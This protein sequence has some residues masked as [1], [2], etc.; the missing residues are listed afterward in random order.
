MIGPKLGKIGNFDFH[1]AAEAID[2]GH[3]AARKMTA[4]IAA[5][6]TVA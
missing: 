3:E 1:H 6:L 5:S 4:E 2:I